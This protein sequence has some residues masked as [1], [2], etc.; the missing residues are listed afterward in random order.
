MSG[1]LTLRKNQDGQNF[2]VTITEDRGT[3][4]RW[5]G[6]YERDAF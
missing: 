1:V 3:G 5:G 2:L 6:F 4:S